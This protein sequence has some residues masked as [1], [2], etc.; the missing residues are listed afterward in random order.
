MDP[1]TI[2]DRMCRG[3]GSAA[4][5]LGETYDLFRHRGPWRPMAPENRIMQLPV[6]FDGGDPGYR[7]P[8]GYERA[9]RATFDSIAVKVGDY[10]R[11]PR[12]VLFVAALPSMLRP[13]CVL[14]TVAF[15]VLRPGGA[16]TAGL[17]EYGGVSED[18]LATVLTGWPGQML[19]GGGSRPGV[20]PAEGG[21]AGFSVLLPPTP[22]AIQGSDLLQDE[23]GQRFL[24][25][26]AEASEL[27]WKLLVQQTGV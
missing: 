8:R 25:R 15:D 21:Q 5:V 23:V 20:L 10:M 9:L 13:L 16:A 11:G 24:V 17:N 4:R 3:M 6:M 27:G 1:W 2:Q 12:G 7:R 18:V 19:A 26:S 22:V 14:T